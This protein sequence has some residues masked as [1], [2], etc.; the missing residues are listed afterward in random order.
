MNCEETRELIGVYTDGELSST[1]QHLVERHASECGACQTLINDAQKL[2]ALIR[3]DQKFSA[4]TSLRDSITEKLDT[5]DCESGKYAHYS[6]WKMIASHVVAIATSVLITSITINHFDGQ[7]AQENDLVTTHLRHTLRQQFGVIASSDRHTIQP[8]FSGK[9]D[10]VPPVIDLAEAGFPLLAGRVEYVNGRMVAAL[11]Y[12]RRKHR[13]SLFI[14][15]PEVAVNTAI[16]GVNF[17]TSFRGL[18][19]SDWSNKE[20]S[21]SAVTDANKDDLSVFAELILSALDK[22]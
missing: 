16:A 8:W 7:I 3:S 11:T 1:E 13:I 15:P 17:S 21:F 6:G 12:G 4:P 9:I 14:L 22:G 10:Y 19:I 5:V 20:F 2:S 18:N